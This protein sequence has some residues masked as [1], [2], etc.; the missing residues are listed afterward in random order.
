M[1]AQTLEGVILYLFSVESNNHIYSIGTGTMSSQISVNHTN[2]KITM[3]NFIISG[4]DY[5]TSSR[6]TYFYR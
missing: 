2:N 4:T 6:F 1:Q 3:I 5:G